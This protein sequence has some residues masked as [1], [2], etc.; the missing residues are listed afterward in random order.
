MLLLSLISRR[1]PSS[2]LNPYT[3]PTAHCPASFFCFLYFEFFSD[4]LTFFNEGLECLI[5]LGIGCYKDLCVGFILFL[6]HGFTSSLPICIGS[7]Y[8]LLGLTFLLDDLLSSP[9][10]ING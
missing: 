6:F 1:F 2:F 5:P 7:L 4:F 9:F 10:K 3:V 8:F